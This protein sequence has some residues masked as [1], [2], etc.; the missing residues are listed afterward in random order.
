[1]FVDHGNVVEIDAYT[2]PCSATI[3]GRVEDDNDVGDQLRVVEAELDAAE[4]CGPK[5]I[6]SCARCS[7]SSASLSR[8]RRSVQ[9]RWPTCSKPASEWSAG[10]GSHNAAG[11]SSAFDIQHDRAKGVSVAR[12]DPGKAPPS[13]APSRGVGPTALGVAGSDYKRQQDQMRASG[14]RGG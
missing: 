7:P 6:P 13:R 10:V 3:S 9:A 14:S 1:M 4:G 8:K 5:K 12:P 11:A 2:T